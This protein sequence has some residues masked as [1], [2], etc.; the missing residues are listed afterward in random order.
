[1]PESDIERRMA[2]L[3]YRVNRAEEDL[4]DAIKARAIVNL[5][6]VSGVVSL[7]LVLWQVLGRK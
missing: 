4:K 5:S 6:L 1:M 3:E 7:V 2:V